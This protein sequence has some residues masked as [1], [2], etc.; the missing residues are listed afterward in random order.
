[1]PYASVGGFDDIA[2]LV[3]AY[4]N[5][6]ADGGIEG[7]PDDILVTMH[8]HVAET[9][10][11]ARRTAA[12]AFDLYVDTRLYARKQTYD[13]IMASGLSLMGGVD[14]VRD[15]VSALA[16]MGVSHLVTLH[17]FGLIPQAEI[18]ASMSRLMR[19]VIPSA[20]AG[21]QELAI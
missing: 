9:D 17:N 19:R 16:G 5:G 10:E 7:T 6:Q 12:E 1:M 15:K 8:T 4:R 2:G 13:D 21:R 3:E 14:T 18:E 11:E 20:I